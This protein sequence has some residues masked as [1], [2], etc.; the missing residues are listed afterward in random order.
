MFYPYLNRQRTVPPFECRIPKTGEF[1]EFVESFVDPRRRLPGA[2]RLVEVTPRE[3]GEQVSAATTLVH[4]KVRFEELA[5]V[6][7]AIFGPRFPD[8]H[9]TTSEQ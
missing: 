3:T 5:A 7:E 8:Q 9:P 4:A 1:V 2:L 6:F